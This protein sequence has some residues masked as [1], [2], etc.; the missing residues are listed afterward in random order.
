M[1]KRCL[2]IREAEMQLLVSRAIKLNNLELEHHFSEKAAKLQQIQTNST[3]EYEIHLAE[4]RNVVIALHAEQ[5]KTTQLEEHKNV[6]EQKRM[7][8]LFTSFMEITKE[9]KLPRDKLISVCTDGAPC[10]F[11]SLKLC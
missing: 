2:K 6:L 9:K 11:A 7:L 4:H 8:D 10:M 1:S 5:A 3:Q